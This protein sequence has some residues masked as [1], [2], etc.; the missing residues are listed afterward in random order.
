MAALTATFPREHFVL[1]LT[2]SAA[3][4]ALAVAYALIGGADVA[5]VAVLV[6][7]LLTLLLLAVI[8]LVPSEVLRREAALRST[9]GRRFRDVV[10]GVAGGLVAFFVV[11]GGLSRPTPHEGVAAGQLERTEH[12]HAHDT[13]TAILADFRGLDT[14]VEITVVLAA[15]LAVRALLRRTVTA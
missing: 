7:V 9:R 2:I 10:L 1:V 11:W 12:V 5:L 3:G 4:F 8:A 6:E 15:V 14:M 13:V